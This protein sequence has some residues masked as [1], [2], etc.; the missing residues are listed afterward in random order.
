MDMGVRKRFLSVLLSAVF[1]ITPV[2]GL[3]GTVY[4]DTDKDV[5]RD[6]IEERIE[7]IQDFPE[8]ST[9]YAKIGKT[10]SEAEKKYWWKMS[11][12]VYYDNFSATEKAIYNRLDEAAM[13]Y[14]LND[15]DINEFESEAYKTGIPVYFSDIDTSSVDLP[16][17]I[18]MFMN[19]NSQYFYLESKASYGT[20]FAILY[21]Y[22]N[23]VSGSARASARE[24]IKSKINEYVSAASKYSLPEQKEHTVYELMCKNITYVTGAPYNQSLYSAVLGKTVCAGYM[25]LFDAVMNSLGIKCGPVTSDSHG[26]NIIYLHGNWYYVDVTGADQ[27]W[28][29]SYKFYNTSY[30]AD[31]CKSMYYLSKMPIVSY[32]CLENNTYSNPYFTVNSVTYFI[33]NADTTYPRMAT[34]VSEPTSFFPS[35]VTYN[36][37]QYTVIKPVLNGWYELDGQWYYFKNSAAPLS[38]WQQINNKW[39]YFEAGGAMV[40]GWRQSGDNW[41]YFSGSGAMVT[42]W[43]ELGGK[44]YYFGSDGAMVKSWQKIAGKWYYFEQSGAMKTGWY[45]SGGKWY[46]FS[47]SGKMVTGWQQLGNTWYYFDADGAMFTGW[48]KSGNNWYY[49]QASGAMKTGWYLSGSSWYYFDNSGVMVTGSKTINGKTYNFNSNGVCTN[50]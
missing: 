50:P 17:L 35:K 43:Q 31:T 20:N 33:S 8:V 2:A 4:A 5:D 24:T 6:G 23:F 28:G 47:G 32:S 44:W 37:K 1:A 3:F 21:A 38:G 25:H 13:N 26:W 39:Y 14:L 49:L 16:S 42:D 22:E 19:C 15:E 46:Y 36:G 11:S 10:A 45:L 34:P 12:E 7:Y 18:L 9:V 30:T 48:L 41:F 27:E 40:T 29:V